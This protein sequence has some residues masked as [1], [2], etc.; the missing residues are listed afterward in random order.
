MFMKKF[1]KLYKKLVKAGM[2][3]DEI[4]DATEMH[5]EDDFETVFR[6]GKVKSF[7]LIK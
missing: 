5:S 3:F 7:V 1:N 2:P 4:G 6:S